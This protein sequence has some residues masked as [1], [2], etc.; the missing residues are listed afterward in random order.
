[1]IF[2]RKTLTFV[3]CAT[4]VVSCGR[5]MFNEDEYKDLVEQVQPVKGI[6][7]SHT[8]ELTK[9]YY[10]TVDV[11]NVMPEATRLQILSGNPVEDE[12]VTILGDYP[13]S[14]N[15][16][17]YVAFIAPSYL[18]AFYAALVD[19]EDNYT[20]TSFTSEKR[21]INFANPLAIDVKV[22]TR[23]LG[24]Q[25]FT[26]C[27]ENEMPVPGDY[28]Y[29]DVV[30]RISQQRTAANQITLD[31]TLAAVGAQSQV[32]A[33]VRLINHR[34]DDIESITTVNGETFDDGYK[35]SSI[36]FIKGN[37][38]LME[39]L[40]GEAVI[41]LF[42]DAHWA[43]GAVQYTNGGFFPRYRYN[44]AKTT[45]LE[46]AMMRPR[47]ISYVITFKNPLNLNY[48]TLG[49]LDPFAIIEYNSALMEVHAAYKYR[50]ATILHKRAQLIDAV[51]LP[52]AL[53]VPSASF[54]YP[55]NGINIGFAK[56]DAFFGAYMTSRHAFGEWA[57]NAKS[58][59]DW[60]FYPTENMVY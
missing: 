43:T 45:G 10:M 16:R 42:E 51:A 49:A 54:R 39:G 12:E 15:D 5:N 24:K 44:V 8:W 26:Y 18:T 47:T 22:N 40:N 27:F 25:V 33:A 46:D 30:L 6:D 14:D 60:Y 9:Q 28:D 32:A 7:P 35:K 34:F 4:I 21:A 53:I 29:N 48:F 52:W 31:V 59:L 41:N 37:E 1:M 19:A 55:L 13:L 23:Q 3:L 57:A 50:S 17:Q 58:T 11:G 2:L 56:D 20:I 36:S 38:L